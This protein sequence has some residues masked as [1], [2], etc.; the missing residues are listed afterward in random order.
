MEV[1]I[2]EYEVNCVESLP[3]RSGNKTLDDLLDGGRITKKLA[4]ESSLLKIMKKPKK[5]LVLKMQPVE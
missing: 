5:A 4:D 3:T 2:T 1:V